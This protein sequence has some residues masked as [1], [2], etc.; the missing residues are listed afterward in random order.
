MS[1]QNM[2]RVGVVGVGHLG[3]THT[4]LWKSIEGVELYGVYDSDHERAERVS[5][6]FETKSFE[7]L[8]ALL[9]SVDA[10]SIVT[11]TSTHYDVAEQA[12]EMGVHLL[13][14]KPIT[15]QYE[16][17]LQLMEKASQRGIVIQVGHIERFNP[18]FA[19]LNGQHLEPMFIESHRLAQFTTRATDVA[20]VLDLMIHDIDLVLALARSRVAEVRASGVSVVSDTIDIANARLEFENGC[21]ANLTA[22]R[23]SQRP[24][25]KMRLFQKDAYI[26]IDFAQPSVE[27]FR[28]IDGVEATESTML[29]GAIGE[30]AKERNIIYQKL[31]TPEHNALREEL[32]AFAEAIRNQHNPPVTAME[33]A[34]ALRVAE[35]IIQAIEKSEVHSA[36]NSAQVI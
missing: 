25:R 20:V 16:Q 32:V 18:A 15:A 27:M 12:I 30:G 4:R 17:A 7:S 29:L 33:G 21:V 10:L 35:L 8:E 36:A 13:V 34:E 26:S 11:P 22:S 9:Q 6:E 2:L 19:A 14:E 28:I 24:M 31:P 1:E 5:A 3:S 23:I